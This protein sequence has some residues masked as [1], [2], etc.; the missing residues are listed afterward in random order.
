MI[1]INDILKSKIESRIRRYDNKNF[2]AIQDILNDC[3]ADL[4]IDTPTLIYCDTLAKSFSTFN[5]RGSSYLIYDNCLMEALHIFNSIVVYK[6]DIHDIDKLFYKLFA[7]ELLI[8][9]DLAH[10]LYF[11]GKYGQLTFTFQNTKT[12][13]ESMLSHQITYQIYF[14]IG[15]ELTHLALETMSGWGI[16]NDFFMI[17]QSATRLLAERFV[18][19]GMSINEVL[20]RFSGYFVDEKTQN[21]DEYINLLTTSDRFSHFVEECYCDF[22]GIKLLLENYVA[23]DESISAITNVLNFLIILE[24]IKSNLIMGIKDINLTNKEAKDTL[25]FSVLRVQL[26][27]IILQISDTMEIKIPRSG[28][29]DCGFITERL[30]TFIQSLPSENSMRTID[31]NILKSIKKTDIISYI[32][33]KLYYCYIN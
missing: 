21:I 33:K 18:E 27:L 9:G 7:E 22:T 13:Y 3:C 11:T 14:L 29:K 2:E 16:S 28:I 12:G 8:Q 24:S 30:K 31:D 17:V 4:Q 23:P 19:D 1:Q 15:H 26:L 25:Y 20:S 6:N 5:L 10:S 32:T